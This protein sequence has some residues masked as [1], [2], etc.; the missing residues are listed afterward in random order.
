LVLIIEDNEKNLKLTRD[1]LQLNGLRTL[2][3]AS[4]EEGVPLAVVHRPDVI[5]LDIQLPGIDGI[6][7]VAQFRIAPETART[8]IVALTAYAMKG[9]R[10][11]LLT[12]GFDGYLSKP[13]N[14]KTFANDV[15]EYIGVANRGS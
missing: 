8:P 2:E 15:R 13:I 10:E 5:L 6:A 4:A 3:A 1:L 12:A 14:V 7:A 9:D 11:R